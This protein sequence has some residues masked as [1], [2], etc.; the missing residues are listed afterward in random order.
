MAS[1]ENAGNH[2]RPGWSFRLL[3]TV[4]SVWNF[5]LPL[6]G[7][8]LCPAAFAGPLGSKTAALG[9]ERFPG[10]SPPPE[11]TNCAWTV[12]VVTEDELW[13]ASDRDPELSPVICREILAR[14]NARAHYY[15]SEDIREGR[16]M[17][18][19]D[20]FT[21]F[22]NWTPLPRLLPEFAQ[23][24]MVILVVKNIPFLGWYINGELAGDTMVCIGKSDQP[25]ETGW[26]NILEKDADH[27]SRSY[28]NSFGN[29]AWMPWA[30]RLYEAV[31]I[32]AGDITGEFCSHG[33]VTL[34]LKPAEELF[35]QAGC[36]TPVLIVDSL[37]ELES[38]PTTHAK[39]AGR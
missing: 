16:P 9:E 35:N 24:Q 28:S 5:A 6:Q 4:L 3:I 37:Q 19:P 17:K 39:H 10:E 22:R 2:I 13:R 33:C 25:T 36:G 11:S 1:Q 15:I 30:L 7:R 34:P 23:M 31:W 26:Y 20:D 29:P 38:G 8:I 14:L 21:A 32:H 27:I 18:V 12:R